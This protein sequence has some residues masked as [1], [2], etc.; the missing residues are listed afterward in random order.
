[1]GIE[2][3][4]GARTGRRVNQTKHPQTR[5]LYHNATESKGLWRSR[6]HVR[7]KTEQIAPESL[8]RHPA[9]FVLI[10]MW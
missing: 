5:Y 6:S 1:M 9:G 2:A 10:N 3:S 4:A 7:T 8:T